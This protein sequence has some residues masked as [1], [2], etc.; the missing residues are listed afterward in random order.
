[1]VRI[2]DAP[3]RIFGLGGFFPLGIRYEPRF[4]SGEINAETLAEPEC[5]GM[6]HDRA[7]TKAFLILIP[8]ADDVEIHVCRICDRV[9]HIHPSLRSPVG[10]SRR[11]SR[12][13]RDRKST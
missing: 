4:F 6:A 13:V 3:D 5:A 7:D 1:M 12:T 8:A 11:L 10:E 2:A 9:I